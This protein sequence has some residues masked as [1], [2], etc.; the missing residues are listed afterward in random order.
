MRYL[1]V[2]ADAKTVKGQKQG[3]LTGIL[4]LAP[5]NTSGVADVCVNASQGC[6]DSCLFTAGRAQIFPMINEARIR[7]TRELFADRTAFVAVLEREIQAVQRKADRMKLTPCIRI[8]G[9]SDLPWLALKLADRF[10]EVQFYDYTKHPR[11]YERIRPNYHLTFSHSETNLP[12]CLDNLSHGV[13]VAVCFDTKRG[14]SLPKK[15]HGFKVIDGDLS[16]VRFRDRKGVVVGLRAKGRAK[17]DC[18]GFVVKS[19]LV[20]IMGGKNVL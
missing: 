1:S 14:Q 17:Q 4:Y 12:V 6:K 2:S 15:W 7:K 10:P 5:S 18:T 19:Q 9:T 8:N 13:N 3:Y 20:Q 11:A 16:D